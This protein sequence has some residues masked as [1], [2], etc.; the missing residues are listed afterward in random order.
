M[1]QDGIL[2]TSS[3]LV[4]TSVEDSAEIL[5]NKYTDTIDNVKT[6]VQD[7]EGIP[8][9]VWTIVECLLAVIFQFLVDLLFQLDWN[10]CIYVCLQ[11]S[12]LKTQQLL[13]SL[14][15]VSKQKSY[16]LIYPSWFSLSIP[17]ILN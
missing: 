16:L 4:G 3:R 8:Q 2:Y 9:I 13:N 10:S 14:Y 12:N 15:L 5:R 6:K 11:S 7:K 1:I 17:I